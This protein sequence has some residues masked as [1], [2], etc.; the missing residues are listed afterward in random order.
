VIGIGCLKKLL[1]VIS[2]LSRLALEITLSSGDEL[3]IRVTNI[4]VIVTL[5]TSG[6]DHDSLGLLLRPPL[7]AFGAPLHALVGCLGRCPLTTIEGHFPTVLYENDP[8]HLLTRG[9]LGCDVEELLRGLRLVTVELMHQD[10]AVRAVPECQDD[11]G[12]VDLGELVS[13]LEKHRM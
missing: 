6:S 12:V 2:R 1:E 10:S 13:L 9:M 8:D 4:L 7:V 11:I 5:V 3:L